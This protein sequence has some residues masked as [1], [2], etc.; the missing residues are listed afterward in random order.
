MQY[1]PHRVNALDGRLADG[2]REVHRDPERML[3]PKSEKK[4][5]SIYRYR[6]VYIFTYIGLSGMAR[7]KSIAT[8]NACSDLRAKEKVYIYVYT[9]KHIYVYMYICIYII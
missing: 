6:Y 7:V 1:S 9:C 5:R 3:R 4:S 8:P 2:A